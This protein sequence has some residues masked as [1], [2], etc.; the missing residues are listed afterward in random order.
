MSN[1]TTPCRANIPSNCRVHG[2]KNPID[3]ISNPVLAYKN[4]RSSKKE[5]D[6]A[7]TLEQLSEAKQLVNFDQLVYDSTLT[8]QEELIDKLRNHSYQAPLSEKT[9]CQF[10]IKESIEYRN[11]ILKESPAHIESNEN[12]TKAVANATQSFTNLNSASDYQKVINSLRGLPY[13]TPIAMRMKNGSYIYDGAGNGLIV[14]EGIKRSKQKRNFFSKLTDGPGFIR[15]WK[16]Q[17]AP[18]AAISLEHSSMSFGLGSVES[19][20]VLPERTKVENVKNSHTV[21]PNGNEAYHSRWGIKGDGYYYELE[22]IEKSGDDGYWESG[23]TISGFTI[24]AYQSEPV[25]EIKN[26]K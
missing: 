26:K 2:S 17:P 21:E 18:Q 3:A 9:E 7:T 19:I 6:L 4:L 15:Q 1:T 25:F 13:G 5:V 24:Q 11:K 16:D 20:Y 10:R 8:G 23:G 12:F 14:S 22:G